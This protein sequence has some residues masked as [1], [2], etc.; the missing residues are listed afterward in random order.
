MI[1][2]P[3]ARNICFNGGSTIDLKPQT[4]VLPEQRGFRTL[5]DNICEISPRVRDRSAAL[6][7]TEVTSPC[8]VTPL[9]VISLTLTP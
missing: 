5:S 3:A 9:S 7:L 8:G 6:T 4:P 2:V 1:Q